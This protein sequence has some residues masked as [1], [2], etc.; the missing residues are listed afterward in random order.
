MWYLG[1][2]NWGCSSLSIELNWCN[3]LWKPKVRKDAVEVMIKLGEIRD[4]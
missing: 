3:N 4:I 1:I 2:R